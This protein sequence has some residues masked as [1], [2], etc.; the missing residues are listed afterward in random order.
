[1]KTKHI[2]FRMAK[3]GLVMDDFTATLKNV[4]ITTIADTLQLA[5]GSE[6]HGRV[7]GWNSLLSDDLS[8]DFEE[9]TRSER[10]R[11]YQ[12]Y[13]ALMEESLRIDDEMKS[14]GVSP[15]S[16]LMWDRDEKE[17]LLALKEAMQREL[18]KELN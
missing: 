8:M 7:E 14:V 3:K 6:L 2:A 17:K 18:I 13:L 10:V 9:A 15:Q 16:R 5:E 1:M 4:H 12:S 11:I